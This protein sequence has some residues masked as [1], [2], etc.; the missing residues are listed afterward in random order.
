MIFNLM[1]NMLKCYQRTKNIAALVLE[2]RN[3]LEIK[4]NVQISFFETQLY[5]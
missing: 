3:V 5:L 1:K 2:S 4:I